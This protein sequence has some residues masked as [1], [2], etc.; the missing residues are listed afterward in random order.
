[1]KKNIASNLLFLAA[2]SA[3]VFAVVAN[4]PGGVGWG[5]LL[6]DQA[7]LLRKLIFLANTYLHPAVLSF[8]A[9]TLFQLQ[10]RLASSGTQGRIV[11]A[12]CVVASGAMLLGLRTISTGASSMPSYVLGMALGYTMMSRLY[13]MRLRTFFGSVR[14]PWPV[15]R[16]D[17]A[18]V[19]EINR[20]MHTRVMQA[21]SAV[22]NPA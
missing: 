15:W 7:S 13:A 16:G 3:L 19:E 21:R 20:A 14:L 8:V 5:A 4:P 9:I 11:F 2:V 10:F 18:A 12:V 17:R 22:Q 6:A 1:M